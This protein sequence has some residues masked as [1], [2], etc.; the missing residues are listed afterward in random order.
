MFSSSFYSPVFLLVHYFSFIYCL[1]FV[2][3]KQ[4]LTM[5]KIIIIIETL[6]EIQKNDNG[7][8]N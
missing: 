4:L 3:K 1:V 6:V 2:R 7:K 8:I 5:K